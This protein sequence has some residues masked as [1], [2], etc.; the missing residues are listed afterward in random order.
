MQ[1]AK[2]MILVSPEMVQSLNRQSSS[3]NVNPVRQV[4]S[5][6]DGSIRAILETKGMSDKE[7]LVEYNRALHRY[8]QVSKHDPT[9]KPIPVTI[10]D[11]S[12]DRG[13]KPDTS[14]LNNNHDDDEKDDTLKEEVLKV[15]PPSARHRGKL[16]LDHLFKKN[17]GQN[18]Y[19][20]R[21]E[22]MY[23]NDVVHGSNIIDLI[24]DLM[25]GRKSNKPVGWRE[26]MNLLIE[27][28]TPESLIINPTSRSMLQELKVQTSPSLKRDAPVSNATLSMSKPSVHKRKAGG[29]TTRAKHKAKKVP[30]LKW[31]KF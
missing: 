11:Q 6:L 14:T 17:P 24:Y 12:D 27:I 13:T 9:N 30:S 25:K 16:L 8:L 3:T 23:N 2:K 5:N 22:L 4:L 29:V 31:E 21:R 15:L 26:F 10:H 18:L 28:N 20:S 1:N 19:N 7:K